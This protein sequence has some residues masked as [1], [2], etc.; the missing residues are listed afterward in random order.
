MKST[1]RCDAPSKYNP[2]VLLEKYREMLYS[3]EINDEP[4][5][6]CSELFLSGIARKEAGKLKLYNRIYETVFDR[7]WVDKE[8]DLLSYRETVV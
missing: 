1:L 6:E 2:L 5:I 8:I 4:T 3:G 7:S